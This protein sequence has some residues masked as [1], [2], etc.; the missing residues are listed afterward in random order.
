MSLTFHE[1]PSFEQLVE[2]GASFAFYR[3]PGDT[4][5]H[6][7]AQHEGEISTFYYLQQLNGKTGF[8]VAPFSFDNNTPICL[9]LQDVFQQ[10]PSPLIALSAKVH[11][12]QF[13]PCL[14]FFAD[15]F[16]LFR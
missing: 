9:I 4:D 15:K 5:I 14:S 2:Q 1:S 3:S 12:F 16:V 6:F 8:V 13:Y 10:L 7:V 11:S